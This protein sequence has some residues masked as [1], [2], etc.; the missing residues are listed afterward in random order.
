MKKFQFKK[1]AADE[2]LTAVITA[3]CCCGLRLVAHNWVTACGASILQLHELVLWLIILFPSVLTLDSA[4]YKIT[5][6]HQKIVI[7]TSYKL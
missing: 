1:T 6:Q 5:F 3:C 4:R 7:A 2:S